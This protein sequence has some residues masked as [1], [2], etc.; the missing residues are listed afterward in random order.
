MKV[1]IGLGSQLGL[2][3]DDLIGLAEPAAEL[4]FDSIWTPKRT[5][6]DSFYLCMR[7][8]ERSA[9]PTTPAPQVGIG[10]VPA[11]QLWNPASLASQAATASLFSGGRF[12]LG[13]GTGGYGPQF[14]ESVRLPNRPIGVMRDYV[15]ALRAAFRG[16]PVDYD[17]KTLSLH[18]FALEQAPPAVPIYLAALGPQMLRLAGECADGVLLNW[19]SPE[20]IA[21]SRRSLEEGMAKADRQRSDVTLSMYLRCAVDDD[22]DAARRI[23]ASEI[24]DKIVPTGRRELDSMLGYRGQF[25]RLG[26]EADV[27]RLERL[28]AAG[29]SI[30]DLLDEVPAELCSAAGYYGTAEDAPARVAELAQGL[31]EVVVRV[32]P[33]RRDPETAIK[34]MRALAPDRVRSA[35]SSSV[36]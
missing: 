30:H 17:G 25:V 6:P 33:T 24:L 32:V 7:W 27:V 19:S 3:F 29:A 18:N 14:W 4:G 8:A 21:Q 2:S 22:V 31:D 10:V 12:I 23:I 11:P 34:T 28:F 9:G 1:G 36:A 26:F 15:G 16:G 13:I 20:T 5:M 35:M